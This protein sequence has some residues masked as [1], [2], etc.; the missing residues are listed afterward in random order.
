MQV[1]IANMLFEHVSQFNYFG[2]TV[3][4]Q[5]LIQEEIKWRLIS[6]NACYHSVQNLLAS[7]LLAQIVKIRIYEMK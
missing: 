6:G 1:K 4:N 5:N 7:R 3:T 2:V